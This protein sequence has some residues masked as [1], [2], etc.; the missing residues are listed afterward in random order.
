MPDG[1][2]A[3]C[4]FYSNQYGMIFHTVYDPVFFVLKGHIVFKNTTKHYSIFCAGFSDKEIVEYF[5]SLIYDILCE[6]SKV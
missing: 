3:L 2:T 6:E 1:I 4:D 5:H